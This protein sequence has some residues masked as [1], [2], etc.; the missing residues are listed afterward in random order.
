[1]AGNR[2]DGYDD[3]FAGGN[4]LRIFDINIASIIPVSGFR[5]TRLPSFFEAVEYNLTTTEGLNIL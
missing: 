1:L 4:Y 2:L 3:G 5:I